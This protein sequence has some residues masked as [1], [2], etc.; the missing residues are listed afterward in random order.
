MCF[1]CQPEPPRALCLASSSRKSSEIQIYLY[2]KLVCVCAWYLL[3]LL[4]HRSTSSRDTWASCWRPTGRN[5][6]TCRSPPRSIW[7]CQVCRTRLACSCWACW[8]PSWPNRP[9]TRRAWCPWSGALFS[10]TRATKPRPSAPV[11]DATTRQ[12]ML[13]AHRL[14][15]LNQVFLL[16]V[17]RFCCCC[18]WS[19]VQILIGWLLEGSLSLSNSFSSIT[20]ANIK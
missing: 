11:T 3:T 8:R 6:P 20:W 17:L 7:S 12:R 14:L 13:S 1:S 2:K 18:K 4:V 9:C 5:C 15:H 16:V 10:S 19:I